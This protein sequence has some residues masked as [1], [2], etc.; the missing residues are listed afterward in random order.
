MAAFYVANKF[1]RIQ[2]EIGRRQA[3]TAALAMATARDKLRLDLFE[4][5]FAVYEAAACF[6]RDAIRLKNVTHDRR[7]DYLEAINSAMWLF[8]DTVVD[9]LDLIF[10]ELYNL[11]EATEEIATEPDSDQRKAMITRKKGYLNNLRLH[12]TTLHSVMAPYLRFTENVQ[13]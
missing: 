8:D 4:K 3:E 10:S 1:G 5:R 13:T 2:A 9:H 7:F 12:Q 6:I 11:I